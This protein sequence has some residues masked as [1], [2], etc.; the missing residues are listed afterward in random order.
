ML[1]LT[2]EARMFIPS[3]NFKTSATPQLAVGRQ[4]LG[5]RRPVLANARG[6]GG[7]ESIDWSTL[8]ESISNRDSSEESRSRIKR[9][10][11][12]RLSKTIRDQNLFCPGEK[13]LIAVSGGQDSV[14]L[15]HMLAN[16][17]SQWDWALSVA[18][19][20]HQWSSSSQ[21]QARMSHRLQLVWD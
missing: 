1:G 5:R 10:F 21:S 7:G 17:C 9:S 3:S 13:I 2:V 18:Y 15:L 20:D 6:E 8:S 16:L 12:Q 4:A 14:C 19:C 11:N